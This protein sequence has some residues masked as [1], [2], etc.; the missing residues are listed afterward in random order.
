MTQ[1][2]QKRPSRTAVRIT[3]DRYQWLAAWGHCVRALHDDPGNRVVAVGVEV[4]D[5]GAV[6]DVV[7][8]WSLTP[9]T[10]VQAKYAVDATT[11]VNVGYLTQKSKAGGPSLTQKFAAH[12]NRLRGQGATNPDLVLLTNRAADPAD[13]LITGRDPRTG[14][15]LPNAKLGTARSNR[16]KA[17]TSWA[18][19]AELDEAALMDL[20]SS[21]RFDLARDT[22]HLEELTLLRMRSAGLRADD[23]ALSS[24]IDWVTKQVIAGERH[25]DA[26]RIA[27][28]VDELDL[29]RGPRRQVVSVATLK[30]DPVAPDAV[31]A[32]DWVDRF[33]GHDAYAKRRPLAP[34]TWA[35]LHNDI[36]TIP[37]ALPHSARVL[38]TGSMR[39]PAAFTVG[40]AMRMVTNIDLA[41][42]QGQDVWSSETQYSDAPAPTVIHRP[43]H[44]G[45]DIA[46]AIEMTTPITDDVVEYLRRNAIPAQEL[47]T[48]ARPAGTNDRF[49]ASSEAANALAYGIREAVRPLVRRHPHIHLFLAAPMGLVLLL[50]HRWNAMAATTVYEDLVQHGY[51]AAFTIVA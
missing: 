43:I 39:L 38:V 33:D 16:G 44:Q 24:G 18:Q 12:H 26:E 29:Q 47:I 11:P 6:D 31:I 10:Y 41:V 36:K 8:Y 51:E 5:A 40:T 1:G 42:V 14:L 13:I 23:Q 9:P 27:A 22:G 2:P 50:G 7:V 48:I 4:D 45:D 25:L 19:A 15:L 49:I 34:A 28:A 3:G 21:W 32:L 37:S 30:P 20:L 17:R 35:Q 46:V